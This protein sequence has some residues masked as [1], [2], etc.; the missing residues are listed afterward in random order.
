VHLLGGILQRSFQLF[1]VRFQLVLM[2]Q[3][4]P[5]YK[6]FSFKLKVEWKTDVRQSQLTDLLAGIVL[7]LFEAI[8]QLLD[9]FFLDLKFVLD[10]CRRSGR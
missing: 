8:P 9:D 3:N 6:Y 10:A 5:F 4:F 2:F 7:D 1:V